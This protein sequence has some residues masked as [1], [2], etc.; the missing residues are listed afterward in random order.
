MAENFSVA[1][2]H[3]RVNQQTSKEIRL[4]ETEALKDM[5]Q[6]EVKVGKDSFIAVW[7]QFLDGFHALD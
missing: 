3:L 6:R 4:D 1:A 5:V 2:Q 7:S